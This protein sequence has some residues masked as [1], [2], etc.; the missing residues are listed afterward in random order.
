M[1]PLAFLV[2]GFAPGLF[3]LWIIARGNR[4]RPDPTALVVRTFLLGVLVALPVVLVEQVISGDLTIRSRMPT[5]EAAVMAFAVAGL[6]EELGKFLLVRLSLYD[7]PY[8]DEPLRGL[9]YAS[10]GALGF[11]SIENVGFMFTFGPEVIAPRAVL[12]TL[13]HVAFSALWG[14]G[15]GADRRALLQGQA[16]RGYAVLGLLAAIAAHG[17]YDFGIFVE[18]PAL[19]LTSFAAISVT[20]IALFIRA[21][22]GSLHRGRTAAPFVECSKCSASSPSGKRFCS[23]CGTALGRELARRCGGCRTP[24][25]GEVAYCSACGVRV[26]SSST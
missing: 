10:A 4:Q 24:L 13:G 20:C 25:P 21:N 2:L 15:L 17:A 18:N 19:T 1:H 3:W 9:V 8:F 14:Y 26:G 22:R 16:A 7:S 23:T 5:A 6:V 12:A 11:A